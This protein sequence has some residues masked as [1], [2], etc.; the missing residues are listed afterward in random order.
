LHVSKRFY[1]NRPPTILDVPHEKQMDWVAADQPDP[2]NPLGARGIGEPSQGAGC[3]AV[4]CAIADA[5]GG[6][7]F[8]RTPI[9]RDMILTKVEGLPE[10]V[11][12]L[13][14]HS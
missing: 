11:N 1:S 12:R 5:M 2:F 6:A 13:A 8:N 7:Y 3:G 9:M 4:Q 14:A 10:A